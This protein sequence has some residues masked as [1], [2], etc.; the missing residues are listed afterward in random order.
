MKI[1]PDSQCPKCKGPITFFDVMGIIT[2]F[3]CIYC[4][5]CAEMVF[6]KHPW[7]LFFLSLIFALSVTVFAVAMLLEG[8]ST[9]LSVY[10][11]ALLV[12]VVAEFVITGYVVLKKDL[13]IRGPK[14]N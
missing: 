8:Y 14:Q 9:N 10:L 5:T 12:L 6:L 1:L 2:P 4:P 11:A 7:G 3:Q 13:V